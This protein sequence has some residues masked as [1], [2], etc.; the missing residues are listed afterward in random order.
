MG[1]T[2]TCSHCGGT[3]HYRAQVYAG[4][5][6]GGSLPAGALHGPR[7]DNIICGSCGLTQWFVAAEH[8]HLVREKLERLD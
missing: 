1:N 6:K 3:E 4:G 5:E 8:L 7:Y 2:T